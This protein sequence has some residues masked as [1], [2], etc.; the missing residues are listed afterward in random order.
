M[1]AMDENSP[2]PGEG[3]SKEERDNGNY[4][5]LFVGEDADGGSLRARDR[6]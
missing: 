2:K 1:M 4:D 3:P 5:V 6:R